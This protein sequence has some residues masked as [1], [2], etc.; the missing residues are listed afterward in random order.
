MSA[1]I[2]PPNKPAGTK[3]ITVSGP[4]YARCKRCG[5]VGQVATAGVEVTPGFI[6]GLALMF[7]PFMHGLAGLLHGKHKR[8]NKCPNCD[9]ADLQVLDEA[10]IRRYVGESGY[11]LYRQEMDEKVKAL[12]SPALI[13]VIILI[14]LVAIF[15]VFEVSRVR[16]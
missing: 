15:V 6:L 8:I 11:R 7:V 2:P 12:N 3:L 13:P 14:A 4:T 5:F 16:P 10:G 9:S 1:P